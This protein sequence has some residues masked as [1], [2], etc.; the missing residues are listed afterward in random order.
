MENNSGDLPVVAKG[1]KGEVI[2]NG[3]WYP[4]VVNKANPMPSSSGTISIKYDGY[5]GFFE[6]IEDELRCLTHP[7]V[8]GND[9]DIHVGMVTKCRDVDGDSNIEGLAPYRPARVVAIKANGN[10][11][12]N[13]I[14][15][16]VEFLGGETESKKVISVKRADLLF[17]TMSA[18]AE[19]KKPKEKKLIPK[20]ED[21]DDIRMTMETDTEDDDGDGKR[22]R[23]VT[24]RKQEKAM[25]TNTGNHD[26][27]K[28]R[29]KGKHV[30]IPP[31]KQDT[32]VEDNDDGDDD[33]ISDDIRVPSTSHEP[34]TKFHENTEVKLEIVKSS[35]PRANSAAWE[36]RK[37]RRE[38]RLKAC[39]TPSGEPRKVFRRGCHKQSITQILGGSPMDPS[40]IVENDPSELPF[41][42]NPFI[43]KGEFYFAGRGDWNPWSPIFPG[44]VG[45]I[46]EYCLEKNMNQESFHTFVH[47][48]YKK[49]EPNYYGPDARG[50]RLYIGRYRRATGKGNDVQF[51]GSLVKYS[52]LGSDSQWTMADHHRRYDSVIW[53]DEKDVI[54]KEIEE[55]AKAKTEG[56]QA[57]PWEAMSEDDKY[58]ALT[59]SALSDDRIASSAHLKMYYEE[60]K[61]EAEEEKIGSWQ[62]MSQEKKDTAAWIH[63]LLRVDYTIPIVPVEYVD[64]D[65]GLYEKLVAFGAACGEVSV[66]ENE[67]GPL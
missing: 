4:V 23:P 22:L 9:G 18:P 33:A 42:S 40:P 41:E 36:E 15:V 32:D 60:A 44:D 64:Y 34:D 26:R 52:Q 51:T 54:N 11:D 5:P 27:K 2:F 3:K 20:K 59:E 63:M 17:L 46:H 30:A 1:M 57:G 21:S 35:A 47:C 48:S 49:H 16:D 14:D 66:D 53:G 61:A 25:E 31:M 65:E 19:E 67:L 55:R 38:L 58:S 24:R 28:R 56:E 29:V 7:T 13:G 62:K 37:T 50:K 6:A 39:R 10:G 12:D 8:T 43:E 45:C